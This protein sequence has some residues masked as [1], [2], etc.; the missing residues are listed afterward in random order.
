[1]EESAGYDIVAVLPDGFFDSVMNRENF[2][3]T[4]RVA[5]SSS[6]KEMLACLIGPSGRVGGLGA[7]GW[8]RVVSP[9]WWLLRLMA[10][11]SD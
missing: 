10:L 11:V 2:S 9:T 1:M 4:P 6:V 5:L 8:I 3:S 7:I